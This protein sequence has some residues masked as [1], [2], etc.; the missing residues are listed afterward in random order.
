MGLL[1]TF[2]YA[3]FI[4]EHK[5]QEHLCSQGPLSICTLDSLR[6]IQTLEVPF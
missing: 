6:H 4:W 1:L 5:D 3:R 2:W